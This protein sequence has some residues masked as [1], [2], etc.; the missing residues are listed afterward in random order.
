MPVP[1]DDITAVSS[2]TVACKSAVLFSIGIRRFSTALYGGSVT[3]VSVAESGP[4]TERRSEVWLSVLFHGSGVRPAARPQTLQI[5]AR[6]CPGKSRCADLPVSLAAT[7]AVTMTTKTTAVCRILHKTAAVPRL[8][9][10][11]LQS[12]LF[13][14]RNGRKI[15]KRTVVKPN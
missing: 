5:T 8:E 1:E 13:T 12:S 3:A 11:A 9:R 2:N 4:P 14:E 10:Q 15:T 7:R 6:I